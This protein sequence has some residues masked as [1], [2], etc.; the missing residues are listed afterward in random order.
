MNEHDMRSYC[1]RANWVNVDYTKYDLAWHDFLLW[2]MHESQCRSIYIYLHSTFMEFICCCGRPV[3]LRARKLTLM[4][5][6]ISD[7]TRFL[8]WAHTRRVIVIRRS[9]WP[10]RRRRDGMP[11]SWE[12]V[13]TP[14]AVWLI[15]RRDGKGWPWLIRWQ[16]AALD[17]GHSDQVA[18]DRQGWARYATQGRYVSQM[19]VCRSTTVVVHQVANSYS[20]LIG[21]RHVTATMATSTCLSPTQLGRQ[22]VVQTIKS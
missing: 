16:P 11:R 13:V 8:L 21:L 7:L 3:R 6:V 15:D 12:V 4:G 20:R 9:A 5:S 2:C 17:G 14:D 18:P 22:C 1:G 19:R 10:V